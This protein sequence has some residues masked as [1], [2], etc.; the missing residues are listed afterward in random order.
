MFDALAAAA[1]ADELAATI[2]D[3][4]IQ[5]IGLVNR[6]TLAAEVYAGG[7]RRALIASAD[8]RDARIHLAPAMPSLDADLITPFGLLLR[9][10]LRGGIIGAIEQPPLERVIVLSI[11]KR[12]PSEQERRAMRKA[13][14][15]DIVADDSSAARTD[16]SH[17]SDDESDDEGEIDAT[18]VHLH[19]EIMGRHSNLILVD[20]QG[21]IMDAAKRVNPSMSRVRPV[22]PHRI[23]IPPP[24][25]ERPDPRKLTGQSAADLLS[26]ANEDQPL[27]KWL[28]AT[29]R[30]VSPQ[31]ARE[32]AFRSTGNAN[33]CVRDAR[34]DPGSLAR[35]TRA[36]LEPLLTSAWSPCVYLED[37]QPDDE[38]DNDHPAAAWAPIPMAHLAAG[39]REER[40]RN[41]SDAI[42]RAGGDDRSDAPVKHAQ[43]RERLL[44]SIRSAREKHVRRL[45]NVRHQGEQ[46]AEI[47]TLRTW[48]EL[49]YANLWQ[50]RPG[51]SEFE[52]DG[53]LVPLDPGRPAKD[54]AQEYFERY[55][56][57]QRAEVHQE[58]LEGEIAAELAWLDQLDLLVR[59]AA[60]FAELEAIAGEWDTHQPER[61]GSR[62]RKRPQPRRPRPLLDDDGNAVYI[63]HTSTQN[64]QVTFDIAGPDD[65][66]LHAR[67][68]AG[69]HVIIRWRNPAAEERETTVLAAAALA[70]WYSAGRDSARVEVDVARRRH[71]RKIKGGRSGM[72][73]YRN[74]RTIA[75]RP[76]DESGVMDTLAGTTRE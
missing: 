57:A 67:G 65:T 43:R 10:Y 9:K 17:D 72:V 6:R 29:L 47:D 8:D 15:E 75:V 24:P 7:R 20:D 28:P 52:A 11:A 19:V 62:P 40:V 18:W 71:V 36:L 73:T 37:A 16:D 66:W 44:A 64:D 33:A 5:R 22:Q 30:G 26:A 74:E 41:I 14:L 60:G 48:G 68:V 13:E 42:F 23:F 69:S 38:G 61:A 25:Q 53:V 56:N 12:L 34:H 76:A 32:I 63:G 31:M 70:A 1:V 3:G 4:R 2:L 49:I 46:A 58:E 27:A 59:Q 45:A 55:R 35:E 21:E 54:V 50:I 51:Q 39:L